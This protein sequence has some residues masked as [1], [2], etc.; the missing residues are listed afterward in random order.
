M[1]SAKGMFSTIRHGTANKNKTPPPVNVP[2][3]FQKRQNTYGPPPIR[4]V[5]SNASMETTGSGSQPAPPPPPPMPMRKQATPE[6]EEPQGEWAD[7]LYDY[8]SGVRV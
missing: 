5:S 4:R 3:A 7:A 6:P 2:S 1:S 8:K